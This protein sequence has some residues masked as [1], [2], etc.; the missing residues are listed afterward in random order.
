[1]K[2]PQWMGVTDP[3]GIRGCV[4]GISIPRRLTL[5][6]FPPPCHAPEASATTTRV[7][8]GHER[9]KGFVTWRHSFKGLCVRQMRF[10]SQAHARGLAA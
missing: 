4:L 8:F 10:H 6:F 7:R 1:M 9:H 5:G 2:S 3:L